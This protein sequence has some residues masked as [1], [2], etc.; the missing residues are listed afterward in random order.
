MTGTGAGDLRGPRRRSPVRSG[1]RSGL[2]E[3]LAG[4]TANFAVGTLFAWSL[5]SEDA[6]AD[7]GTSGEAAAA[8]FAGALVVFTVVVLGTGA[9]DVDF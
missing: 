9:G 7:V 6:A 8:V 1:A 4:A 5:V 3:V 2:R